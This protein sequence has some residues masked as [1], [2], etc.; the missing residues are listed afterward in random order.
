MYNLSDIKTLH[1]ELTNKC[2]AS[3]PM[4]ARNLQGGVVNPF[5]HETEITY[6]FFI[7]W[8][9]VD[10]IK[11]LDRVLLCGN[12]GDPII[13]KDILK[14]YQYCRDN[15]QNIKLSLNTNGSARD[16]DFWI[17][18]AKLNVIVRFG[19]DGLNDTHSLYRI[20]TSF[21]KVISNATAFI[22][23]GGTA[24]WDML[25]FHHNEHQVEECQQLSEKLGFEEF[26][27]K[28]TSRFK[29]DK[30]V[31]LDKNGKEIYQLHPSLKSKKI[32]KMVNSSSKHIN[33]KII[34]EKSL[35]IS[36]NGIV[37]PCCWLGLDEIPHINPSRIDYLTKIDKF[38]SLHENSLEEIFNAGLF[39][40]IENTWST[41]PLIECSRQ[42][43]SFDKFNEQFTHESQKSQ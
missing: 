13:A 19:I 34:K 10:F 43:G 9:S 32:Y 36:S 35:Y 37:V 22:N 28:D 26:V 42:C 39:S 18:I 20:G 2:Q 6:D 31:V 38:Y 7:K 11:Q 17:E 21:E 29:E 15:N 24:I 23:A 12:L 4:C 40:K 16:N 41:K 1:I 3:C 27:R 5:I 8:F 30:L 14:I 33:C 25:V